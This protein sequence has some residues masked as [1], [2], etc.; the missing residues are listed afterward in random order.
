MPPAILAVLMAICLYVSPASAQTA[1]APGAGANRAGL[2]TEDTPPAEPWLSHSALKAATYKAATTAAN[3]TILSIATGGVVAGA[4]LTAFGAAAALVVYAVNDYA[5]KTRAPAPPRQEDNQSFDVAASFWR[6]GE[7]FLTY[8]A[9]TAWI[10]AAKLA[11]LYAYTGS[12][13]TT[14]VAI[15][16]STMVNAGLFFANGFAWDYYDWSAAPPARP[17]PPPVPAQMKLAAPKT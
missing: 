2:F 16:T 12:P 6:T 4:A 15:G 14:L 13:A 1:P 9:A 10:K 5:W 3:F 8:K 17:V 7:T 11:T